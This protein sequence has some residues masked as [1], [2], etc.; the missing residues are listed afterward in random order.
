MQSRIALFLFPVLFS[1]P[2]LA[3]ASILSLWAEDQTDEVVYTVE[4]NSQ[5]LPLLKAAVNNDPNPAK[6]GGDIVVVDD[7]ALVAPL[8]V[9][10]DAVSIYRPKSDQISVY[11]VREG[12]T[13]SQ[14][15]QMFH[16][17]SNTIRWANNLTGPIKPGQTL[18]ILPV[19][20]VKHTI[21]TGGTIEDLAKMYK[22][23]A[24]EIALFNGID[25]DTKLT[26]GMEIIIPNG[27]MH[28]E[29]KAS[30]KKKGVASKAST[31]KN[32]TKVDTS[33]YFVHPV[34]SGIRTQGIH[35]NNAVD[36]A[37][38]IGTPLR[39]AASGQVIIAKEDGGWYGGYANY[40]VIQHN[41]GTQT[42][43]AHMND[44]YV[45]PGQWVE[46]A[47]VIGEVGNTGN[48]TGPHVHFEVRGG[49]N[50]F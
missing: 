7:V 6:G 40:V 5:T 9:T 46:Q 18:I 42:L 34:P 16:V 29:E 32:A 37:A 4:H 14:I 15:A 2:I 49:K 27:E 24:Q 43:Y 10:G 38:P 3:S 8:S 21:K 44:V 12:D 30:T 31:A 41:N 13:L 28:V 48:S 26:P 39:A 20:G 33:G 35:G 22:A 11:V 47:E 50:P 36:I 45:V 23:D 17:T 1:V 25:V 19:T